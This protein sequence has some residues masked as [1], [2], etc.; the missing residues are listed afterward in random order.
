[1]CC[2][3]GAAGWLGRGRGDSRRPSTVGAAAC[4]GLPLSAVE[5]SGNWVAASVLSG[6]TSA[7]G[8]VQSAAGVIVRGAGR[9]GRSTEAQHEARTELAST[10]V[11]AFAGTSPAP[12]HEGSGELD[13]PEI[14]VVRSALAAAVA[15]EAYQEAALLKRRLGFLQQS[16]ENRA[17]QVALQQRIAAAVAAEAYA[18]AAGFKP[19]LVALRR[20]DLE[21]RAAA[22][23]RC[24]GPGEL[25]AAADFYDDDDDEL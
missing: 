1:V 14:L 12:N 6:A 5:R 18:E 7:R 16:V 23:S 15:A 19:E 21:L 25:R 2:C 11:P 4:E 17:K 10:R 3:A 13:T 22:A 8:A 9:A 20:R 24:G